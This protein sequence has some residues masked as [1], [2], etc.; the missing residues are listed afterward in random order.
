MPADGLWTPRGPRRTGRGVAMLAWIG[1]HGVVTA[2]QVGRRF[3]VHGDTI[4]QKRAYR[5][6]QK[7]EEMGLLRR[8]TPF[9][10]HPDVLRLRSAGAR[11][12]GAGV[13]ALPRLSDHEIP[14]AL[15]VVE[16]VESLQAA[17]PSAAI[18]TAR[19]V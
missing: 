6:L 1:R 9:A 8:D 16:I 10:R 14:H 17:Y 11:V 7:L 4:G 19:E 3:F 5:R 13:T 12:A 2:Q 18:R 15:V